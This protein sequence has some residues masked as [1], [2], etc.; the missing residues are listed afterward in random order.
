MKSEKATS[1][2]SLRLV[3]PAIRGKSP[4]LDGRWNA[5]SLLV[6]VLED[7]DAR[8]NVRCLLNRSLVFRTQTRLFR[9]E[10]VE[11]LP[12]DPDKTQWQIGKRSFQW[13]SHLSQTENPFEGEKKW[14]NFGKQSDSVSHIAEKILDE[15]GEEVDWQRLFSGLKRFF[16]FLDWNEKTV[17]FDWNWDFQSGKAFYSE[18]NDKKRLLLFFQSKHLGEGKFLFEFTEDGRDWDLYIFTE[19]M[20]LYNILLEGMPQLLDGFLQ[21]GVSPGGIH[22]E[23]QSV[24]DRERNRG[25]VA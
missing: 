9:G 23:F 18:S 17:F 6:R 4:L 15:P 13:R 25:W 12:T 7:S 8:G 14:G 16:P 22:I 3:T 21:K 19:Q 10:I 2:E 24:R 5:T 20:E 11:L 1:S